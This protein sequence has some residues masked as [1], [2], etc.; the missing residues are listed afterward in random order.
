MAIKT[1]ASLKS[2]FEA[3]DVPTETQYIHLIDSTYSGEI[4]AAIVS[5]AAVSAGV[6]RIANASSVTILDS[7]SAG[8]ALLGAGTVASARTVLEAGSAGQAVWLAGT[9]ASARTAI[10]V[11]AAS[12]IKAGLIEIA[13]TAE[14]V[15]GTDATR[16]ITPATLQFSTGHLTGLTLSRDAGGTTNDINITAGKARDGDDTENLIL[17]T[18]ITKQIN[19]AWAVGDDA[20][21]MDTGTVAN[22]TWYHLWLIK[23]TDT[24]VVDALLSLSATAPTM[25]TDYDK[26][27]RIGSVRRATAT[28]LAFSHL[29]DEFLLDVPAA[30]ADTANPGITAILHTLTTPLGIQ[31]DA[32]VSVIFDDDNSAG[33][34]WHGLVTSPDQADTVASGGAS[35]VFIQNVV[36]DSYTGSIHKAVRTDAS[37]QI[38]TRQSVSDAG[39]TLRVNTLGW[40]D[41]RGRD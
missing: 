23:R 31:V 8:Q 18:E 41:R 22:D 17:T 33:T 7:G 11:T 19:A 30:D 12:I 24:N 10:D 1:P 40:I 37:S 2:F 34:A 39:I 35:D 27:R 38:R 21:G 16:S 3:G 26:K 4:G 20:G 29:G 15:T 13:T 9:G 28:N 25:P 36:G 32:L 6:V 5:A 14:A